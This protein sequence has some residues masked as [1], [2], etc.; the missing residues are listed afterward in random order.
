[1]ETRIGHLE[2]QAKEAFEYEGLHRKQDYENLEKK[3]MTKVEEVF[4]N[5][6]N[7]QLVQNELAVMKGELKNL[8]MGSGSTVC[9]EASTGVG[10]GSGTFV[11]A[12]SLTSR[13][14]EI[15]G[16]RRMEFKS[17]V[18]D[19][20]KKSIQGITDDEVSTLVKDLERLVPQQAH[21]WIDSEQTRKERGTWPTK[22][23]VSMW[24]KNETNLVTMIDFLK[25]MNWKKRPTRF[26]TS[27]R[28]QC[29]LFAFVRI[30]AGL[31]DQCVFCLCTHCCGAS[32]LARLWYHCSQWRFLEQC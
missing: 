2:D 18:T 7:G 16:P 23:M 9:S 22:T 25:G 30:V 27:L 1:M 8:K 29:F 31:R 12:P 32:L 15:F 14:K 28:D 24:F 19:Y 21:K 6:E 5:E 26:R 10:L 13:W 17:C 20:S 11:R 3:M 4:K